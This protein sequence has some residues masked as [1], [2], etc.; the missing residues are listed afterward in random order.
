MPILDKVKNRDYQR[1]WWHK[2]KDELLVKRNERR[3]SDPTWPE[4]RKIYQAIYREKNRAL[5][6][7]RSRAY[8]K[9]NRELV[10]E[11][12]KEYR[13]RSCKIISAELKFH[14]MVKW[15]EQNPFVHMRLEFHFLILKIQANISAKKERKMNMLGVYSD[16]SGFRIKSICPVCSQEFTTNLDNS[17]TQIHCSEDC[18]RK[19]RSAT[20]REAQTQRYQTKHLKRLL[21]LGSLKQTLKQVTP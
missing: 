8:K 14:S 11:Q 20:S 13:K 19:Y 12:K 2:H 6:N 15:Y 1:K 18:Y 10:N 5:V 7:Q 3:K 21:S 9:A 4:R 17:T 16:G